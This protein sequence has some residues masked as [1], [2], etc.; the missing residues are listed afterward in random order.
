MKI[1]YIFF[2]YFV[3]N[4]LKLFLF[5]IFLIHYNFIENNQ[6]NDTKN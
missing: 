2:I 4:D 6:K 1:L 5:F 3:I